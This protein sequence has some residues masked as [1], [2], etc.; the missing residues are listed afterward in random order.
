MSGSKRPV[1]ERFAGEYRSSEK[2]DAASYPVA[3]MTAEERKRFLAS[4][5]ESM[6]FDHYVQHRIRTQIL[7]NFT[8]HHLSLNNDLQEA[9]NHLSRFSLIIDVTLD[10]VASTLM[11]CTMG[12]PMVRHMVKQRE[13]VISSK[14]LLDLLSEETLLRFRHILRHE[15]ELYGMYF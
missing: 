10:S 13:S 11:R 1:T 2:S 4:I 15:L 12:W 7:G 8:I 6:I 9:K 14:S 5:N 3:N